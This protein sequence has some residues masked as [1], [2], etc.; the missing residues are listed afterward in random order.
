MVSQQ[1]TAQWAMYKRAVARCVLHGAAVISILWQGAQISA[2]VQ[3]L[4]SSSSMAL[5]APLLPGTR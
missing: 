4:F 3:T 1:C 5:I 2:L